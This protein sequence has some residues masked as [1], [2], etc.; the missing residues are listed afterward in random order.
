MTRPILAAG[1][2]RRYPERIAKLEAEK[3]AL[4][5][6]VERLNKTVVALAFQVWHGTQRCVYDRKENRWSCELCREA[7]HMLDLLGFNERMQE[8]AS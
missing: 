4:L 7:T 6:E 3:A 1:E 8:W 2:P 5:G